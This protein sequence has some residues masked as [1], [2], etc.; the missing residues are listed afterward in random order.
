MKHNPVHNQPTSI[1]RDKSL[2][3]LF[4]SDSGV[5]IK[6]KYVFDMGI[7]FYVFEK[8]LKGYIPMAMFKYTSNTGTKKK[9]KKSKN[10]I[11]TKELYNELK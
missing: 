2:R 1:G 10:N 3:A 6:Y 11:E 4:Y 9:N 8:S 5:S 7:F